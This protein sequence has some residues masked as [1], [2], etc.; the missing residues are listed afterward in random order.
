VKKRNVTRKNEPAGICI[1]LYTPVKPFELQKELSVV[2]ATQNRSGSVLYRELVDLLDTLGYSIVKTFYQNSSKRNPQ[3]FMGKGKILE[4]K[5]FIHENPVK[6][7]V[8]DHN[9]DP[10][11]IFKIQDIL[12]MDVF[13]RVRVILE[14]FVRN[15]RSQ[16]AKLQVELATLKYEIPLVREWIHQSKTG[17][18]P[19]FRTGGEF[20]VS[21]YLDGINNRCVKIEGMLDKI[22]KTR[23]N[24]RENKRSDGRFFTSLAGYTNAG[25]TSLLNA[26]S[27]EKCEVEN[28]FFTTLS[29]R[30][31][32]IDAKNLPVLMT[33]TIGFI[34]FLPPYLVKAFRSTLEEIF[35]ADLI[36]L[37]VDISDDVHEII[38][39]MVTAYGIMN[40]EGMYAQIVTVFN[41]KDLLHDEG[42]EAKVES[43]IEGLGEAGALACDFVCISARTG[44][45][46]DRLI[47]VIRDNLPDYKEFEVCIKKIAFNKALES[48]LYSKFEVISVEEAEG[49]GEGSK[50]RKYRLLGS[51][52]EIER[53]RKGNEEVVEI[54]NGKISD[55]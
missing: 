30:T 47:E 10:I 42:D 49:G 7:V 22:K 20:Q 18:H 37:V 34:Q 54:D 44:E 21:Q 46:L 55:N 50:T 12:E 3:L 28:K 48:F 13:D 31:R 24:R 51:K 36:V 4:I 9:L 11:Q 19:G 25:K 41:K 29:T 27:N 45:N 2:V 38:R 32:R 14:I 26:L 1:R 5:E 6:L 8:V 17:E 15:A 53:F 23:R 33:D 16:E 39:K 40:H 35:D 43:I 52:K